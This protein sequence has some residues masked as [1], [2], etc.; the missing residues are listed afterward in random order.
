VSSPKNCIELGKDPRFESIFFYGIHTVEVVLEILGYEI[1]SYSYNKNDGGVTIFIEYPKCT[2]TIH[3]VKD[4]NEFYSLTSYATTGVKQ[5]NIELDGSYYTSLLKFIFE[6]F[7]SEGNTIPIQS[8]LLAV[9]LLEEIDS[10][11]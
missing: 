3:M 11:V 1:K 4:V 9:S 5:K 8:S 10:I 7:L 6:D 2:A